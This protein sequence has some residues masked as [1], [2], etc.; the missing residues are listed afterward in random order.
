[1]WK[2]CKINQFDK[3]IYSAARRAAPMHINRSDGYQLATEM[4]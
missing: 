3:E 2:K 1:M 4:N